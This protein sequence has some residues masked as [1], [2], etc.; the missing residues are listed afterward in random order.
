VGGEVDL[1]NIRKAQKRGFQF[2]GW[3]MNGRSFALV[4]TYPADELRE[5]SQL[6]GGPR[7]GP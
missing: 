3:K 4:G 5:L 1:Q 7:N 2:Y 6:I